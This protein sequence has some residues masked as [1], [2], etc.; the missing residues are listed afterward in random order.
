M[1]GPFQPEGARD[2]AW[3]TKTVAIQTSHLL[4]IMSFIHQLDHSLFQDTVAC[5]LPQQIV[6][7]TESEPSTGVRVTSEP[8]LMAELAIKRKP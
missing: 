7:L 2:L 5:T 6:P 4:T 1:E 3:P 8:I